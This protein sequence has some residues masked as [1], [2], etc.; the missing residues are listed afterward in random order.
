M[1]DSSWRLIAACLD[2]D[3]RRRPSAAELEQAL[4]AGPWHAIDFRD[5][6]SSDEWQ[7]TD[8]ATVWERENTGPG[9]VAVADPVT[10]ESRVLRRRGNH[11]RLAAGAI[12]VLAVAAVI[13]AALSRSLGTAHPAAGPAV[14]VTEQVT[15]GGTAAPGTIPSPR[16]GDPSPQPGSTAPASA[17]T[18]PTHTLRPSPGR[19][20]ATATAS[21]ATSS[22]PPVTATATSTGT[23]V[24]P[25]S[26]TATASAPAPADTP[27]QCGSVSAAT[28]SGSGKATGQTL[29]ACIRISGGQLDLTGTLN[30]TKAGWH[31][32]IVLVL[33]DSAQDDNATYT[34]PVCIPAQC[35]F[36]TSLV[37]ADGQWTVQPEWIKS[38]VVQSAG[39]E[40]SYVDF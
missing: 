13:A 8:P 16:P 37:P 34:S 10:A 30:G 26:G 6:A 17:G 7:W 40:P 36:S 33:E 11:G 22:A 23:A 24:P 28:M 18:H 35:T 38:G 31:E 20:G 5:G 25:A 39:D 14:T 1:L 2:K 19:T 12:A 9:V 3:P 27:W 29:Q 32:Q 4:R 15:P 21:G